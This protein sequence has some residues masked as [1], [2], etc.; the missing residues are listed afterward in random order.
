MIF[1]LKLILLLIIFCLTLSLKAG[2]PDIYISKHNTSPISPPDGSIN[3]PYLSLDEA[4][5]FI[6]N[7]DITMHGRTIHIAPASETYELTGSYYYDATYFYPALIVQKWENAPLP[8]GQ[9]DNLP[10]VNFTNSSIV[11]SRAADLEINSLNIIAWNGSI[12]LEG[13]DLRLKNVIFQEEFL[14][15][16]RAF[17]TAVDPDVVEISGLEINVRYYNTLIQVNKENP[18]KKSFIVLNNVQFIFDSTFDVEAVHK[19]PYLDFQRKYVEK[20]SYWTRNIIEMS[21][22]SFK[23]L[24]NANEVDLAKV[25]KV[26]GFQGVYFQNFTVQNID[27]Q[28]YFNTSVFHFQDV[29]QITIQ[30]INLI[31]NTLALENVVAFFYFEAVHSV[32]INGLKMISNDIRISIPTQAQFLAQFL[33]V[34]GLDFKNHIIA[35]NTFEEQPAAIFAFIPYTELNLK[36]ELDMT[37]KNIFFTNNSYKSLRTPPV[38]YFQCEGPLLGTLLVENFTLSEN[39]VSGK[40][41]DFTIYS[42]GYGLAD[43]QDILTPAQR[44]LK[45][46]RIVNNTNALDINFLSFSP[47]AKWLDSDECLQISVLDR[48]DI[49]DMEISNNSF[50]K[51]NNKLWTYEPSLFQVKQSSIHFHNLTMNNNNFTHY[52]FLN[53]DH[54]PSSFVLSGSHITN[55]KFVQGKF[56]VTNYLKGYSC[57]IRT[58]TIEKDPV[59]LYRFAFI[60]DSSFINIE[61]ISGD[62]LTLDNG[63]FSMQNTAMKNITLSQS[64]TLISTR[65]T[66]LALL[67]EQSVYTRDLVIESEVFSAYPGVWEAYQEIMARIDSPQT[68]YFYSLYKNVFENI[69]HDNATIILLEKFNMESSFI[70]IQGNSFEKVS[71]SSRSVCSLFNIIGFNSLKIAS[72]NFQDFSGRI[73]ALSLLPSGENKELFVFNNTI[74]HVFIESFISHSTKLINSI[75]FTHNDIDNLHCQTDCIAMEAETTAGNWTFSDNKIVSG[76]IDDGSFGTLLKQETGFISLKNSIVSHSFPQLFF[77]NNIVKSLRVKLELP[78]NLDYPFSGIY[79]DTQQNITFANNTITQV[80][81]TSGGSLLDIKTL[82]SFTIKD[83]EFSYCSAFGNSKGFIVTSTQHLLVENTQFLTMGNLGNAGLFSQIGNGYGAHFNFRNCTFDSVIATKYGSLFNSRL[84]TSSDQLINILTFH[85]ENCSILNS[86]DRNLIHLSNLVCVGCTINNTDIQINRKSVIQADIPNILSLDNIFGVLSLDDLRITLP[87]EP[88][89]HFIQVTS[90]PQLSVTLENIDYNGLISERNFTELSL[91]ALDSGSFTIK[92]S[93]FQNIIINKRSMISIAPLSAT[94]GS[95][96]V[97]QVSLENVQFEQIYMETDDTFDENYHS[98]VLAYEHSLATKFFSLKSMIYS[99]LPTTLN[100]KNSTFKSIFGSSIFLMG[101]SQDLQKTELRSTANITNSTFSDNSA[102]FGPVLMVLP[103]SYDPKITITNCTFSKNRALDTGTLTVYNSYL[104]VQ[105][106]N[107][108]ESKAIIG[109]VIYMGGKTTINN[110]LKDNNY[111]KSISNFPGHIRSEAVEI[112]IE[113]LPGSPQNSDTITS[114][115]NLPTRYNNASLILSNVSHHE[116]QKSFLKITY[117]DISGNPTPDFSLQKQA[118]FE[119]PMNIKSKNQ[120][121]FNAY[122]DDSDPTFLK[123]SLHNLLLTGFTDKNIS[124]NFKYTSERISEQKSIL[125]SFRSCIPGEHFIENTCQKCPV[126]T[127]S[128]DPNLPCINCP[129]NAECPDQSK[130]CPR[131]NFWSPDPYSLKITPCRIDDILRCANDND[132]GS[133]A[134]GYAGPLCETCDFKNQYVETGYLKCGKCKNLNLSL[135]YSVLAFVIFTIYKLGSI[136]MVHEGNKKFFNNDGTENIKKSIERSFYVKV[137]LTY[138]QLMSVLY[139]GTSSILTGL[140]L[141]S[142]IGNPASLVAY[143]TQCSMLALG[144]DYNDFLYYQTYMVISSPITE[145]LVIVGIFSVS[146]IFVK[147][148]N[149]RQISVVSLLYLIISFQPGIVG[150]LSQLLSCREIDG[151]SSPF[152]AAHA[153]WFC[154]DPRY[155]NLK[156]FIAIPSL[157][158]WCFIVPV[159]I[160]MILFLNRNKL[161]TEELSASMGVFMKDVKPEYYYWGIVLMLVKLLLAFL[162]YAGH[163]NDE[164]KI[165]I[166]LL[167]IWG[168]QASL[169]AKRPYKEEEFN[170]LEITVMNLLMFN[171]IAVKYLVNPSN[172]EWISKVSLALAFVLN[173]GFILKTGVKI[174]AMTTQAVVDYFAN[175]KNKKAVGQKEKDNEKESLLSEFQHN[176]IL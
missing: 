165:C 32:E 150:N 55:Q 39:H 96:N 172:G 121:T 166:S 134:E 75:R 146:K 72:N 18:P 130:I 128:I 2:T 176:V 42:R 49:Y 67:P 113:F 159:I 28:F 132:C 59:L 21:N 66:P 102:L 54:K 45:G 22:F 56:V 10:K 34:P 16:T 77:E 162:I 139:M 14:N 78:G 11:F 93:T 91:A 98:N 68:A 60:M 84:A 107:F 157:L 111:E 85:M 143:G 109:P 142:Q 175:R 27:A 106:S 117:L 92:D 161:Q 65:F 25:L 103:K 40:I 19:S 87:P 57:I 29:Q 89:G 116:I 158:L 154:D 86:E 125:L 64:S 147:S 73:K 108:T 112:K 48:F 8:E 168:Y 131:Q 47:T 17:I 13:N 7:A 151:V 62:L 43:S 81:F 80:F 104:A 136:Y 153:H 82:R 12:H 141:T 144:I 23:V 61:L 1:K 156:N 119:V 174:L 101:R 140:G 115:S 46:I 148:I 126:P 33:Q 97:A 37:I 30:D 122:I 26:S 5:Q 15:D 95:T 6:K 3:N 53:L 100:V 94:I 127:F 9:P 88:Q 145:L 79:I 129:A 31:N 133:C 38:A 155:I 83:S 36:N 114:K 44:T 63:M 169:R 135:L 138:T 164:A 149:I 76:A 167:L 70:E 99:V 20:N 124:L 41:L 52:N 35:N 58:Q 71:I 170:E 173:V 123:F 50:S 24:N 163:K 152:I 171:V 110:L 51:R 90:S 120:A 69:T 118:T 105:Y 4:F 74:A 137:F 160:F